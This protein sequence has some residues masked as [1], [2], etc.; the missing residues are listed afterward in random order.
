[1][2]SAFVMCLSAKKNPKKTER[3][4]LLMSHSLILTSAYW[5]KSGV[6]RQ[7]WAPL[8]QLLSN[9]KYTNIAFRLRQG[10]LAIRFSLDSSS[11]KKLLIQNNFIFIKTDFHALVC[12][13]VFF[14]KLALGSSCSLLTFSYITFSVV[15]NGGQKQGS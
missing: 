11:V 6:E 3:H 4:L 14:L 13:F 9:G 8:L 10:G 15:L 1:M 2:T 5:L 12:S 7:I